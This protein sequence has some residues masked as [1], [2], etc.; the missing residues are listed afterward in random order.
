[1]QGCFPPLIAAPQ[2][3]AI[4][5]P[6]QGKNLKPIYM[7]PLHDTWN[8]RSIFMNAPKLVGFTHISLCGNGHVPRSIA[9]QYPL[10]H[11]PLDACYG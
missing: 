9:N 1:M 5:C 8:I 10:A 6:T 2:V 11:Q 3:E 4:A 7:G